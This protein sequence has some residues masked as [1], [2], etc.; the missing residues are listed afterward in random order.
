MCHVYFANIP[1]K[2][3]KR[4]DL[5]ALLVEA[6]HFLNIPCTIVASSKASNMPGLASF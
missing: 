1:K 3:L 4:A 5:L 2:I 6:Q